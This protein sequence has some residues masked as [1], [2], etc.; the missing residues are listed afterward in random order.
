MV[1]SD[2]GVGDFLFRPNVDSNE[3]AEPKLV[4]DRF[5]GGSIDTDG[6]CKSVEFL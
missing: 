4:C 3:R 1:G 5:I 6:S 2:I